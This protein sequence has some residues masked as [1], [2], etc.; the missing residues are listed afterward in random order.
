MHAK[1][2]SAAVHERHSPTTC[3]A[4]A[5]KIIEA[6]AA[7]PQQM[8]VKQSAKALLHVANQSSITTNQAWKV[9][10]RQHSWQLSHV[11][12]SV[13]ADAFVH[14]TVWSEFPP[15]CFRPSYACKLFGAYTEESAYFVG[16]P[17]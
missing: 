4:N 17:V 13:S 1:F 3:P 7:R 8:I 15:K 14:L 12:W 5:S 6:G 2:V 10:P 11:I 16:V 9:V